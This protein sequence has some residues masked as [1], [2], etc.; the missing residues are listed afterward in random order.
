MASGRPPRA[1]NGSSAASE[2]VPRAL[3]DAVVGLGSDLDLRG[4]LHRIVQAACTLSA[5]RYGALS[6]LNSN[7]S[8]VD[9]VVE[10]LTDA[11]IAEIGDSP[12]GRG[13]LRG[14]IENPKPTRVRRIDQHPAAAGFPPHHPPMTSF[15][16][17]PVHVHN[18]M[19]GLLYLTDKQ[20]DDEFTDADERAVAAL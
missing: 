16:G 10:G 13:L 20:S 1:D 15:L 12:H 9:L 18:R 6:I 14:L 7:R 11:E 4:V 17:V 8:V 5:A 19:F 3:S 2:N